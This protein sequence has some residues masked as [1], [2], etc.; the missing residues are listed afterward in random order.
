MKKI[1]NIMALVLVA[2]M[3]CLSLTACY[4]DN[5]S[6]DIKVSVRIYD[7]N[8]EIL[9]GTREDFAVAP[10]STVA[11]AVKALCDERGATYETDT[12]G[13]F[14]SFTYEGTKI[15]E[16]QSDPLENGKIPLHKISWSLNAVEMAA[17]GS[18]TM[19]ETTLNEGDAVILHFITIEVT[20]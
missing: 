7:G 19:A 6:K 13:M 16:Y 1:R 18:P 14:I 5:S 11:D 17:A 8:D 12:T 9:I 4:N 20:P 15:E 2:V 10:G 3:L